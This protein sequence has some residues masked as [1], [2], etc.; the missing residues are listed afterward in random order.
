MT[1]F[2]YLRMSIDTFDYILSKVCDSLEKQTT[3]WRR[4]I[5]AEERLVVATG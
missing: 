2:E 3:N 5:G 4:P 1:F